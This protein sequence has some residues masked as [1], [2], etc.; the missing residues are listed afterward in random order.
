MVD[1]ALKSGPMA[2]GAVGAQTS[3]SPSMGGQADTLPGDT[4]A[5]K[6]CHAVRLR[7]PSVALRQ[8]ELGIW[9]EVSW[10][11]MGR[12]ARMVAMGLASFGFQPGDT[13]SI[14]SNT[15][16]EWTYA[17]YGILL[18]GG[19]SSGIYPTDAAAQVEYLTAD[20]GS[21]FL[22]VEDDEQLDKALDVRDRL[23]GLKK[24]VVF[25]MEGLGK[26]QDP[27][28]LSLADLQKA[29]EA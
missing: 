16:R 24:V 27:G 14:L 3:R 2:G 11:E 12:Q 21:S 6:F 23:P 28:I 20:S 9:K 15:R 29:G 8:K 19:V 10:T 18:A 1:L 26:L 13:A 7:G 17:D 25:G 22:F 4:I 5:R